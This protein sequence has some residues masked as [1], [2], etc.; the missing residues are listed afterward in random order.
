[1]SSE[2]DRLP[3]KGPEK[4]EKSLLNDYLTE[5]VNSQDDRLLRESDIESLY[6]KYPLTEEDKDKLSMLVERHL[7]RAFDYKRDERWDS[8]IVETERALLFTPLNNEIRLDLAELYLKRSIQYGYLQKD[9][10]RANREV[11]DA[12]VLEPENRSARKFQKE[13]KQL[14]LMLRGTQHNKRIVLLILLVLI[15]LGA[16]LYPQLRKRFNFLSLSEDDGTEAGVAEAYTPPWETRDLEYTETS[17]L[18]GDFSMEL[19]EMT[20]IRESLSGT[21]ALSIAGYMEPVNDDYSLLELELFRGD[22]NNSLGRIS[23]VEPGD[24]P[25]RMGETGKFHDFIYLNDN[26]DELESLYIGISNS[27]KYRPPEPGEWY[28][29]ILHDSGT[30]PRDVFIEAEGSFETQIEGY[31]RN[32]LFYE[33]RINNKSNTALSRLNLDVQWRDSS[34][35]LQSTRTLSLVDHEALPVKAKSLQSSRIMF[36]LDK[37]HINGDIAVVVKDVEKQ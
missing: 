20:L 18:S 6:R 17:T 27:E 9:L 37:N 1:M 13:L 8:A 14:K 2:D 22:N 10:D 3:D 33:L 23:V 28:P 4:S 30:L 31:D 5:L 12:L 19:T 21:P 34:G 7:N 24:S 29:L 25:L 26:L 32:Y 11:G 16:A 36:D 15:I 35:N